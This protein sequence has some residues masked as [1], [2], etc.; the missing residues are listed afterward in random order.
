MRVKPPNLCAASRHNQSDQS[1][2]SDKSDPSDASDPSGKSGESDKSDT[3][4][5][6]DPSN[7]VFWPEI[8]DFV[9]IDS[10]PCLMECGSLGASLSINDENAQVSTKHFF[11]L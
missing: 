4:D 3:S 11:R 7:A 10:F 2:P 5:T 8:D 1:G 9:R 6:S